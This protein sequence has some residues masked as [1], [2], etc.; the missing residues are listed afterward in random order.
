MA[1]TKSI[2]KN[3][4][5]QSVVKFINDATA[6]T[7]N[8]TLLELKLTDE[9]FLGESN[10]NVNIQSVI[11]SASDSSSNPIVIARGANIAT[12]LATGNVMFL[13][14]ADSLE[15][16]Q[17]GGFPDKT[18]NSSNI[19]VQMPPQSMLYLILSKSAGYQEPNQQ[20]LPR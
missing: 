6:A 7:S 16:A 15:F 1:I 18:L 10:C 17:N 9:T 11:F 8:V 5:Q 3:V 4:R 20:I 12:A 19:A 13:H 14:G 2:L